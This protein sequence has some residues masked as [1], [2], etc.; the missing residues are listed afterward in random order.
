MNI[1]TK[2]AE[3]F[4][5]YAIGYDYGGGEEGDSWQ[6]PM[7]AELVAFLDGLM[8]NGCPTPHDVIRKEYQYPNT[9][10]PNVKREEFC[11][12]LEAVVRALR[13]KEVEGA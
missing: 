11:L 1:T 3:M 13:A 7:S 8:P 9:L 4:V 2:Q 10:V 12:M 5:T 6:R